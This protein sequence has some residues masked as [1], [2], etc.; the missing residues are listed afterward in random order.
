MRGLSIY[1]ILTL[2]LVLLL[3]LYLFVDE[4]PILDF[5]DFN[6]YHLVT[7]V[8]TLLSVVFDN[9]EKKIFGS[10]SDA[11]SQVLLYSLFSTNAMLWY[12]F[13]IWFGFYSHTIVPLFGD[14]I[15]NDVTFF[16]TQEILTPAIVNPALTILILAALREASFKSTNKFYR[17]Y[18]Y[19]I[20]FAKLSSTIWFSLWDFIGK[21]KSSFS[22]ID[23]GVISGSQL[24]SS[25]YPNLTP[26][27][28]DWFNNQQNSVLPYLFDSAS[29]FCS[30]F[31]LVFLTLVL[32]LLIFSLVEFFG[33]KR[34]VTIY[35]GIKRQLITLT[36]SFSFPLI[37]LY[38]SI[39]SVFIGSLLRD[40]LT[41][42]T[43]SWI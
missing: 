25:S 34:G 11:D 20:A 36:Y 22:S 41:V 38:A 30:L 33:E 17:G 29:L 10:F 7:L 21:L 16:F 2:G 43:F 27:S 32:L 40:I 6:I 13:L 37:I 42:S 24:S 14:F 15:E 31:V 28:F 3:I 23:G 18:L 5:T 9:I 12:F 39:V 4:D 19:F 26:S 35:G 8:L 1:Q